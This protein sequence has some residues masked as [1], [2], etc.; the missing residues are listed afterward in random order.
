MKKVWI[1]D[2]ETLDIFTATFLDRDSD[3]TRVF[4][5]SNTKNEMPEM[6]EF[7]S[8]EVN[9]L[10][11]Y[12][13]LNFDAQVLEYMYRYP[14][15]TPQDIR[16][17]AMIITSNNDRRPD[18]PE[19]NLRHKH[20]DLFRAL[21]LSTSAKRTSLKWCEFMMDLDNIE[22]MP[23]QGEGSN[24]EQMV[25]SYNLND[26][27]ATKQ[28]YIKYK[29]EIDLRQTFTKREGINLLN[30]TEPDLA[31][32]LFS[33]YLSKAMGITKNDLNTLHTNRDIVKVSEILFPYIKFKTEK[34]NH[35]LNSFKKLELKES[36]SVEFILN[37]GIDIVYG[38]GGLHAAPNNTVIK[39]NDKFI[40]KSL[41]FISWYPN[42][43]IKNGI[44]AKHLPKDVF[45]PLYESFFNERKSIP[46]SDPRNYILKIL[47]N[48]AYGLSNDKYSFLRDRAV[49]LSICINGQLCLSMLFEDL[50]ES[51]P[52]SKL[53]MVNTDGC[54]LLI[55][56]KFEEKYY[57]ICKK[58]EDLFG[59]GI[60]F[61][62]YSKMI[63]S[64]CNNYIAIDTNNKIKTKGKYEF[65]DIP[66]HKNKSHSIIPLAVHNYW[67]NNIPV[68]KTI[69]E[70]KNIF[71]FCAGVKSKKSD[72]KGNNW[73][74]LHW[75]E[76]GE[77]KTKKLSKTVRYFISNKGKWLYK[78]S[79]D[80][81]KAHVEAPYKHRSFSKDWRVTYFNK[82]FYPK[83]FSEYDIDYLYYISKAR[84]WINDIQIKQQ[85][86]LF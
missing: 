23:S 53:I 39:S 43:A 81:S 8:T 36:D 26:V 49:T 31:K 44:C 20:L 18:V 45:L 42:L 22:D 84:E 83:D 35:I 7:L 24:W 11:G 5:Y 12:N 2:L 65:K 50:L 17:Y 56:K 25:L 29:H 19:W 52:E 59:I 70:H 30:C 69:K 71:D 37:K 33:K 16:N 80:G 66:L 46:K 82:A 77:Y 58:Y 1:W 40:I 55:P 78:H 67:V 28:L 60:E 72:K 73:Y 57:E 4:V 34:F 75:I 10:I 64:D 47:L 48:S 61:V 51:I 14:N 38:L 21:S 41:D 27:I 9:G 15:C 86:T 62:D 68:E 85:L 63:I 54:E 32:K 74:Q 76:D 79:E 6:F 13:S 3:D